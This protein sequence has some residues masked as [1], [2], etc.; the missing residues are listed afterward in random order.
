MMASSVTSSP[1]QFV[2]ICFLVFVGL[3][4]ACM[5]VCVPTWVYVYVELEVDARCF[6]QP[7]STSYVEARSLAWTLNSRTL[8]VYLASLLWDAVFLPLELRNH[9]W[10]IIATSFYV[11][12]RNL[13]SSPHDCVAS[14]WP[15]DSSPHSLKFEIAE[16]CNPPTTKQSHKDHPSI[17]PPPS[18]F[19]P[20]P[21]I[22]EP[23]QW[24]LCFRY[25]PRLNYLNKYPNFPKVSLS[26]L[27]FL[28]RLF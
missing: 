3:C 9:R 19:L 28:A 8:L 15:T 21:S 7:L 20:V 26:F 5:H 23:S 13:N 2:Y 1:A 14:I 17:R 12:A 25:V 11:G 22:P 10:A 24:P 27:I 6:P 18:L 4:V 16:W